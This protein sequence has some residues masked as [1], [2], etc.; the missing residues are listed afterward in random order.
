MRTSDWLL[1]IWCFYVTVMTIG[2]WFG[3]DV[4]DF[5]SWVMSIIAWMILIVAGF[6]I[7]GPY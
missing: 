6:A 5:E 3:P 4:N 1:P 7:R 2:A